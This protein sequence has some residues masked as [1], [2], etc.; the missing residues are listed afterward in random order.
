MRCL[1]DRLLTES[2][3]RAGTRQRPTS[4]GRNLVER[5]A[6]W[7]QQKPWSKTLTASPML[8]SGNCVPPPA[9]LSLD[10]SAN[11]YPD[12]WQQQVHHIKR[13]RVRSIFL[14]LTR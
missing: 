3:C 6:G 5:S 13:L 11:G 10:T 9:S 1:S 2:M 7:E 12:N 4:F 8:D 14:I